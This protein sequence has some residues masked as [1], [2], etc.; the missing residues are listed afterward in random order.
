[1]GTKDQHFTFLQQLR[2][3]QNQLHFIF[4]TNSCSLRIDIIIDTT[5]LAKS[6][7]VQTVQTNNKPFKRV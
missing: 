7:S 5:N 4:Q 1:M 3:N 2:I 6:K